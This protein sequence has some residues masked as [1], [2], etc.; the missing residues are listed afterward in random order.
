MKYTFNFSQDVLIEYT[1]TMVGHLETDLST[2]TAFD[3]DL[4]QAKK[5]RMESIISWFLKE[6]G[7][8]DK[9][10]TLLVLTSKVMDELASC[11]KLYHQM[12]YWVMKAFPNEKAMQRKFGIGRFAKIAD[13]QTSMVLFISSMSQ[14]VIDHRTELEA[15]GAPTALLDEVAVRAEA[16][17][18]ANE[19]QEVMKGNR[20]VDTSER[21]TQL[22]ELF[23]HTR[24]FNTAAEFVF[25]AD[26]TKRDLYRP[27]S[28]TNAAEEIEDDDEPIG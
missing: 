4:N 13:N 20:T 7:D 5:D 27:P 25:Y 9:V 1:G 11:R 19:A 3:P 10:T 22:N 24:D 2:F 14:H 17:R 12:R 16:L 28:N 26:T 21:I 23:Q 6:G 15:A 8:E 18:L